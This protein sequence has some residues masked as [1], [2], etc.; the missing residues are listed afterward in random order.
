M[1]VLV[2]GGTRFVGPLLVHR[3]LAAGHR[4]TLFNRGTIP[5]PFGPRIERLVGD[6]T[7]A[8]LPRLLQN[9]SFDAAVD[10]AAYHG[11]DARGAVEALGGRV[12]HYVFIST[13]QVY[14]VRAGAPRP[15]RESDY[16]GPVMPRPT[17]EE[18]LGNWEY[19]TGKRDCEDALVEAF[20]KSRFPATRIR[21]PVVN[22]ERDHSRR[23]DRY[24]FR[25]VDG[26]PVL[27][28][29]G[30]THPVR[31]VYA[32]EV[33]RF[34]AEILGR[35]QTFGEAYNVSQR[36]TPSLV[37][38]LGLLQGM[39]GSR[40]RFAAVASSDLVAAG[41]S[42]REI[43]PF[44]SKWMSMLDPSKAEA[45]LG[46][47]HEPLVTSL[48]KIVASFLAYGYTTPLEGYEARSKEI[49]LAERWLSVR[50]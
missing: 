43:S 9:R 12:G 32:G 22:G 41:L 42:V 38:L 25:L 39:L 23:L 19:G 3:L 31:H 8:D 10:F 34:L 33:A 28:P 1:H 21:I 35:E 5:D 11:Q 44:S 2:I 45:E 13:G 36:E 49:E 46:F 27:V 26:G 16:E 14:L 4:V 40:A 20:Q 6:R 15:S 48:G 24:L 29:D 30:G 18:E 50:S 47:R 17:D 37:E 7:T